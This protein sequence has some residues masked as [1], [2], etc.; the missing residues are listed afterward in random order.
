MGVTLISAIWAPEIRSNPIPFDP[1]VSNSVAR[2]LLT[3]FKPQITRTNA[4]A[5]EIMGE[6]AAEKVCGGVPGEAWNV[7]DRTPN[8]FEPRQI[9]HWRCTRVGC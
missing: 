1:R 6:D 8:S 9:R 3:E 2:I 4:N 7:P 5:A